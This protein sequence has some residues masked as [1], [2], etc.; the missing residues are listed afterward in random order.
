MSTEDLE[1]TIKYW[2]NAF[3]EKQKEVKLITETLK[4]FTDNQGQCIFEEW[5]ARVCPS[6]DC[7]SVHNQWLDSYEYSDFVEEYKPVLDLLGGSISGNCK[8]YHKGT[9]KEMS[10]YDDMDGML[11]CDKCGVGVKN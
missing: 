6:G 1:D 7:S 11:T 8:T 3:G 2:F 9:M 5:L 10:I 4:K